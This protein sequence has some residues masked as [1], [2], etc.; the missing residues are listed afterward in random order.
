MPIGKSKGNYKL[1]K[2]HN[3]PFTKNVTQYLYTG[4]QNFV[5]KKT[6]ATFEVT[7]VCKLIEICGVGVI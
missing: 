2:G 6:P 3:D 7:S 1:L 5:Y 4:I